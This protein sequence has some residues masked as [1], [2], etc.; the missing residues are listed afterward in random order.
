M[1][2]LVFRVYYER[3]MVIDS[4]ILKLRQIVRFSS[5]VFSKTRRH[6]LNVI[7]FLYFFYRST[8][9]K[10]TLPHIF[11]NFSFIDVAGIG[12][13]AQM[14]VGVLTGCRHRGAIEG[15]NVGFMKFCTRLLN[16]STDQ[17][18]RIPGKI[19]F[20]VSVHEFSHTVR[21]LGLFM[22]TSKPMCLWYNVSFES[23]TCHVRHP[24]RQVL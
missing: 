14:F 16:H 6:L 10:T 1:H 24:H 19:L 9:R 3:P 7:C 11:G 23:K 13:I 22:E 8:R 21:P 5:K 2:L 18:R 12:K 20:I 15:C 17:L 4:L